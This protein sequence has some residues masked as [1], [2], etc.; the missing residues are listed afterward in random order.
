MRQFFIAIALVVSCSGLAAT[1]AADLNQPPTGF[2]ALF[3]GK[4][5]AGWHGMGHFD[6]RQLAAMSPEDR[7]KKRETEM[8]DLLKHWTVQNGE[9]VNDGQGVYLTTDKEYGD[10]E[11]LIDYKMV[12]KGDSGIY[13]RATRSEERRVGK[14]CIPPCRSRWS[15]YH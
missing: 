2:T 5:F 14:E 1:Q 8:V 10:I 6:P 3:N 11:L 15:P 9:I 4:D 7:A 12:P 13:L